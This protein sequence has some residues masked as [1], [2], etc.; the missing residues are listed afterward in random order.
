MR[1]FK[2]PQRIIVM[3]YRFIG[4]TLLAVPFLRNLRRAFPEA[5]IDFLVASNSGEL[6]ARCPYVNNLIYFDKHKTTFTKMAAVLKQN[7]YDTAFILKR[8]FSSAALAALAGVPQRV[9]FDTEFRQLLLTH[10]VA[11]GQKQNHH[12]R[13]YFLDVLSAVNIPVLDTHLEYWPDAKAEQ[14]ITAA[15][16]PYAKR[17]NVQIHLTSSNPAK[18]WPVKHWEALVQRLLAE[19]SNVTLHAVGATADAAQYDA[20]AKLAGD[21]FVNWCGKTSLDDSMALIRHMQLVIGVDSGTLHMASV[22]GVP[23]V[24]LFGPMNPEQ[25]LPPNAVAVTKSLA[26]RPCNLKTPC[27]Y[28]FECMTTLSPDTVYQQVSTLWPALSQH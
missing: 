20:V 10:P 28:Q 2:K 23:V 17:R 1:A 27:R 14:K 24:A 8:S 15:F 13:D 25:W 3:R 26:C 11:Y 6:L 22:A 4:D 9:G 16:A 12:E 7:K 18:Q 5:H 21:R 19:D